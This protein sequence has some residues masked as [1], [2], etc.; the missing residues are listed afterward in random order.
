MAWAGSTIP[1]PPSV[2]SAAAQALS[3]VQSLGH[4]SSSFLVSSWSG[5]PP[6]TFVSLYAGGSSPCS[7]YVCSNLTETKQK[8]T[9]VFTQDKTRTCGFF[10]SFSREDT[11]LDFV[12]TWPGE[13]QGGCSLWTRREARGGRHEAH[14]PQGCRPAGAAPAGTP[15]SSGPTDS[16]QRSVF[17]PTRHLAGCGGRGSACLLLCEFTFSRPPTRPGASF[18]S[19]LT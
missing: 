18:L 16:L 14:R 13:S 10:K 9:W 7:Y 11:Q 15:R 17:T 1:R 12:P 19:S 4:G 3:A 2:T 5:E 8:P 6:S